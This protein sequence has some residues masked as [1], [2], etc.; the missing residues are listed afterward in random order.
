MAKIK[1]ITD[2]SQWA[3]LT[4]PAKSRPRLVLSTAFATAVM[5]AAALGSA[6]YILEQSSSVVL[7]LMLITA[8][9]FILLV[10]AFL[11]SVLIG[12]VFFSGPW[13]EHV[14]LGEKPSKDDDTI[15][16]AAV[17]DHNAEFMVLIFVVILFNAV[18]LN[19]VTG[20][21][22][23]RYHEESFFE[24][25]M[26]TDDVDQRV[27]AL[28]NIADPVN[29]RLW[30][31]EGLRDL[32][33]DSFD[34]PNS[35]VRQ[36]AVWTAGELG[37]RRGREQLREIA[38]DHDDPATR[39]E[40]AFALGKLGALDESRRI[41]EELLDEQQPDQVRIG[42]LQGLAIM[43]DGRAVD[44]LLEHIDDDSEEVMIYAFWALAK[45]GDSDARDAVK[46]VVEDEDHG[47]RRCAALDAFKLVARSEDAEWARRQFRRTD[48]E[49]RCDGRR[50]E[51]PNERVHWVVWEESVRV[52]WLKTVGNTNPFEHERWI[53]RL[54]GDPSLEDYVRDVAAEINRQMDPEIR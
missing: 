20:D 50:F 33:V 3:L 21:F 34:D 17:D 8:N 22:F 46:Q 47:L 16:V 42:A 29:N 45:I 48:P 26:R 14:F 31:R 10:A 5:V 19:F 27:S 1:L 35:R 43:G 18:A 28:T 4:W 15:D 24:V 52:K 12:D 9:M 49:L 30:E 2:V 36:R 7:N 51:E 53:N 37:L 11:Q 44:S 13:R 54:I 32:I 6:H 41:L 39:A 40:A 25:Q 38:A 23:T